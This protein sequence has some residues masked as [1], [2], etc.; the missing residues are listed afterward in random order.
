MKNLPAVRW[1]L[2][3]LVNPGWAPFTVVILHLFL[4][5][6]GLTH[7]FDHLLHFLGGASTG[8]FFFALIPRLPPRAGK[9]P[10]WT[11]HLLAFAAA[12]TIALLWE[13]AEFASDSFLGT[14]VQ[15]S[16]SE[17]MLDLLFGV[18]GAAA[19][20]ALGAAGRLVSRFRDSRQPAKPAAPAT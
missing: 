17:T 18:L 14:A 16:L 3:V 15:R 13:F 8:Y 10:G 19:V 6:R 12:C 20:L 5:E 2:Q 1:L 11:R 4:A 9:L 7:R